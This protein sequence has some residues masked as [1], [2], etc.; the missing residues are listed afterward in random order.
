MNV[1]TLAVA[2][3]A[4]LSC[5]PVRA[6]ESIAVTDEVLSA[7]PLPQMAALGTVAGPGRDWITVGRTV[8]PVNGKGVVFS[9]E[10]AHLNAD[11]NLVLIDDGGHQYHAV[12]L[13]D[14]LPASACWEVSFRYAPRVDFRENQDT[15]GVAGWTFVMQPAGPEAYSDYYSAGLGSAALGMPP[16]SCGLMFHHYH[17]GVRWVENANVSV[18]DPDWIKFGEAGGANVD[19]MKAIDFTIGCTNRRW[20]VTMAQEGRVP[21]VLSHDFTSALGESEEKFYMGWTGSSTDWGNERRMFVF[22]EFSAISGRIDRG[23][24]SKPAP[25]EYGIAEGNWACAGESLISDGKGLQVSRLMVPAEEGKSLKFGATGQAPLY[26]DRPFALDFDWA[27]EA[28][29]TSG[30]DSDGSQGG[31]QGISFALM[32]TSAAGTCED[33]GTASYYYPGAAASAGFYVRSYKEDGFGWFVGGV[34]EDPMRQMAL[35][36]GRTFN[37][38]VRY[39]GAGTLSVRVVCAAISLD[40]AASRTFDNLPEVFYPAFFGSTASW[41]SSMTAYVQN[42]QLHFRGNY[43]AEMGSRAVTDAL[44]LSLSSWHG[45]ASDPAARVSELTLQENASLT[46]EPRT[47]S[48]GGSLQVDEA[49]LNG[50]AS[51]VAT[52]PSACLVGKI[53]ITAQAKLTAVGSVRPAHGRID[54]AVDAATLGRV[55]TMAIVDASEAPGLR[56]AAFRL[57]DSAG[58]EVPETDVRLL[59]RGDVLF[60]AKR[61]GLVFT[62]R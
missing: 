27:C 34:R 8:M 19:P 18:P 60:C 35:A 55:R 7:K 36:K 44:N 32:P 1:Q 21:V 29:G 41:G 9:K 20:T 43:A 50:S 39:D 57:V 46:V 51:I 56:S 31:A 17:K 3:V 16:G 12:W 22:Q 42:Y 28:F 62:V 52:A 40:Y 49:L 23:A 25:A 45:A 15:N 13:N 37:V 30:S 10:L 4:A 61:G 53:R 54:V 33:N 26:R 6:A 38:S 11:G 47:A 5:A 24:T 59:W 58:A 48:R 2:A 14:P